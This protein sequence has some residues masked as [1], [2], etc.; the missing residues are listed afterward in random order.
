MA[1]NKALANLL[2]V[3]F[4]P[5]QS[6]ERALIDDNNCPQKIITLWSKVQEIQA[7]Y[8]GLKA[9]KNDLDKSDKRY[10]IFYK[11]FSRILLEK[12]ANVYQEIFDLTDN[13]ALGKIAQ[14]KIEVIGKYLDSNT[15]TQK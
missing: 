4:Y 10:S 5:D 9:D 12:L 14:D 7:T 3:I 15:T 6:I 13:Q 8:N 2:N 11:A 1:Q